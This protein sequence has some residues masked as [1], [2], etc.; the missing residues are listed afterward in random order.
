MCILNFFVIEG[1]LRGTRESELLLELRLA[2]AIGATGE[3]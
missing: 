2:P 1:R 3:M